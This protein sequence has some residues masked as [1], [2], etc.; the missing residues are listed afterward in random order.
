MRLVSWG[1]I[2]LL[3][4]SM[5]V[6]FSFMMLLVLVWKNFVGLRIVFSLLWL[7]LVSV[8]VF[9]YFVNSSGVILLIIMLVVWVDRMVVISSCRGLWK[10]SL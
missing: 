2:L 10:L 9:G 8:V 6:V 5:S 7:V 3:N 4:C 1:G